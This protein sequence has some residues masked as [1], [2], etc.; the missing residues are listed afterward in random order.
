VHASAHFTINGVRG[1]HYGR[2]LGRHV[3][4]MVPICDAASAVASGCSSTYGQAMRLSIYL[5][6]AV[7]ETQQTTGTD[8]LAAAAAAVS[9][10]R[11][12]P[13]RVGARAR[14]ADLP[15]LWRPTSVGDVTFKQIASTCRLASRP[16]RQ[17]AA[18]ASLARQFASH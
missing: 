7:Y 3:G 4:Q 10:T 2:Q 9:R 14:H 13:R 12:T 16:V 11:I 15:P 1:D 17:A 18:A 6:I 8:C 5:S